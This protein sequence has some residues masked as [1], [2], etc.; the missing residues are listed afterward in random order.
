VYWI[1]RKLNQLRIRKILLVDGKRIR[2][3]T[4]SCGVGDRAPAINVGQGALDSCQAYHDDACF[5]LPRNAELRRHRASIAGVS[6][7]DACERT[8]SYCLLDQEIVVR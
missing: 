3:L 2:E 7:T 8:C 4:I 5:A 1:A 6:S